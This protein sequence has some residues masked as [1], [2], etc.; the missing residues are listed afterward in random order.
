MQEGYAPEPPRHEEE[1]GK[2]AIRVQAELIARL[3]D[4]AARMAWVAEHAADFRKKFQE[5]EAFRTMAADGDL[6]GIEAALRGPLH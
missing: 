3:P 5:D 2:L 4:D 1:P 6:D